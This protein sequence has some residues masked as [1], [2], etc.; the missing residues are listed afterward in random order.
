[1]KKLVFI[2]LTGMGVDAVNAQEN[3]LVEPLITDRPDATESATA[4]PKGIL[5][6]ETGAFYESYK[7]HKISTTVF[8]YNTTLIRYGIISNVELRVGWNFEEESVKHKSNSQNEN[9]RGFSPLLLGFKTTIVQENGWRP[10]IGFLGHLYLPFLASKDYKPETTGAKFVFAFNHT[11]SD[12]SNLGYNI[13][14]EWKDDSSEIA[15]I[16]TVAFGFE[17]TKQLGAFAEVYGDSPENSTGSLLWN[18]G[19]TY[20]ISN[21][22]QIDASVGRGITKG[23]DLLLSAGLSVRIPTNKRNK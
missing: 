7:E 9:S 22:L 6:I 8:T 3:T 14:A 4:L 13:G 11:L 5:Q 1:M 21:D 19:L 12:R 2:L 10:E 20:L 17:I 15:Y 16:Y 23:Q 18:S